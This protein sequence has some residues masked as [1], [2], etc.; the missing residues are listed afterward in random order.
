MT[1][2]SMPEVVNVSGK[3]LFRA[4]VE[5]RQNIGYMIAAL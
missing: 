1:P 5:N 2:M 3:R 4:H